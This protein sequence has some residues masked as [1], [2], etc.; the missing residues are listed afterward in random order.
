MET[1]DI[2]D[3]DREIS[4]LLMIAMGTASKIRLEGNRSIA[5]IASNDSPIM[6]TLQPLLA[7]AY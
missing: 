7:D 6:T 2:V 4:A 5:S 3:S 1:I